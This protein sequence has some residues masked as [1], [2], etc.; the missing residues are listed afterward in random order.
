MTD[1]E[2]RLRRIE[3]LTDIRQTIYT[4]AEAGDRRNAPDTMARI[5]TEHAFYEAKGVA[6]FTGLRAIV[7]GLAGIGQNQVMWSFHLPGRILTELGST[8]ETA[9]ANWQ[10]WEPASLIVD[11]AAKPHWLAGYY[12]A[13]LDLSEGTWKFSRLILN[14]RF[15]T[16]FEGPWTQIEDDFVYPG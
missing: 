4:Y 8:M 13:A 3:A 1:I 11:G 9:T 16:P 5:F 10:V 12:D 14:V 6:A 7:D 15:F 2:T